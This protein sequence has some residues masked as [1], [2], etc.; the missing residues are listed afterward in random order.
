MY[1]ISQIREN[2]LVPYLIS[3]DSNEI[4]LT[5][6]IL[7]IIAGGVI[8]Y[9]LGS[10]NFAIIISKKKFNEDVRTHG[11]GNGGMTNM[12]RTYGK[13]AAAFTVLGDMAKTLLAV[14]I[15]T[16]LAG[17]A[18]AYISGLCCVIG[19]SFPVFFGFRGGKGVVATGAMLLFL[20]PAVF[21]V[22]FLIFL[23]IV[24]ST[25]YM[26][27]GSIMG[28]LLYPLILN[29]MYPITHGG[30]QEGAVPAIISII[31]AL[32]VVWLHRENI[33]RLLAGTENKVSFKKK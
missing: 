16:F 7:L 31:N 25:K 20:D 4:S 21:A 13:K 14:A 5:V 11:S 17:E 26:S 9:L 15:G 30:I 19:H 2:G 22:L 10:L 28:M 27:L 8:A 12:L 29:R 23:L 6:F 1:T 32:L 24:A 18:G 3:G 33:K